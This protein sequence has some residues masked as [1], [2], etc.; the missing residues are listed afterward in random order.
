VSPDQKDIQLL[1]AHKIQELKTLKEEWKEAS[2]IPEDTD[3]QYLSVLYPVIAETER[4][5]GKFMKLAT[6]EYAGEQYFPV[7]IQQLLAGECRGLEVHVELRIDTYVY[8]KGPLMVFKKMKQKYALNAS[9]LLNEE[10]LGHFHKG[11][12]IELSKL[13]WKPAAKYAWKLKHFIRNQSDMR[14]FHGL[15]AR[16]F[17]EPL[18]YLM[19][20]AKEQHFVVI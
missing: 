4:E 12:F 18:A 10:L 15:I 17:I 6:N 16:T 1:I 9:L 8:F 13:G 2:S 19:Q 11:N 3:Y 20:R 14:E 5:L 7:Y